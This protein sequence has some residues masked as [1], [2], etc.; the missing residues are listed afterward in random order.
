LEAPLEMAMMAVRDAPAGTHVATDD[1]ALFQRLKQRATTDWPDLVD[2]LAFSDPSRG[3]MFDLAGVSD[4]L[5]EAL[6]RTVAIP[7]GGRLTIDRTEAMSVIDVD[8]GNSADG[9]GL[10]EEAVFRL[11][12]RACEEAVRQIRLRNL[13]G[14]IVIDCVTL[15]AKGRMRALLEALR[16][17][18]KAD[19]VTTDVLGVSAAGLIEITRQ[20]TGPSLS[21]IMHRPAL[22]PA[23]AADAQACAILRAALRLTGPGRP[24]AVASEGVERVL[25][26]P[27][28]DARAECDRRL[29]RP[30]E[31][32]RG[33]DSV[34]AH[35]ELVRGEGTR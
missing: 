17:L 15:R 8:S 26:G 32:K 7:G 14:L 24:V 1:R 9:G 16:G 23:P 3:A 31:I 30:L 33:P 18:V 25:S 12:K 11:N 13:S 10:K 19:P 21:E 29:G 28:A 22:D 20:R 6:S 2:G 34:P 4:L 5:E 35:V 27:L